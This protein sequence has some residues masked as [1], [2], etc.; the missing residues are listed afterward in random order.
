[1]SDD[2]K[3][4][5]EFGLQADSISRA[6]LVEVLDA[7]EQIAAQRKVKTVFVFDEF[8]QIAN[9]D[10]ELIERQLRS[11]IQ[12]QSNTGYIFLGHPGRNLFINGGFK[13]QCLNLMLGFDESTGLQ[14]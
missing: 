7:A 14:V 8:Q 5:L 9:Y 10:D 13:I 4:Q 11:I 1:M 12:T 6:E 3:P 2:G